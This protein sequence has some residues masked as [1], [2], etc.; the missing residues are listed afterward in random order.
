MAGL[1]SKRLFTRA[2]R[3]I[4]GGVN[5]PV[6]SFKAVGGTPVFAARGA[7]AYL[8]DADGRRYAD[9]C[10]S[11]GP[12]IFGH[13][14]K[15]IISAAQ[16]AMKKGTTFGAATE[17]EVLLA[18]SIKKAVPSIDSVRLTSSGTEAVFSALRLARAFTGRTLIVKFAGSYHGHVDSLLVGA[19]S[20]AATLGMPDSAGV[21]E[22]WAKT[23]IVLP[24]ND[25]Q[26]VVDAF[27]KWGGD[28][29]AVIVE[30]V[31][32]NMGVVLPEPGF[33]QTLRA[34]TS[35][36]QALL[37]FDE[38]I[39]GFRVGLGGAQGLYGIK[40][41]LT[42]LGKIIGGGFPLAAFG[43]RRDIME[44]LAPLGPVY[45]AG[46]L[47]GNPVAVAAGRKCLELLRRANPYPALEAAARG[48][49]RDAEAAAQKAGVPVMVN[50][51]ASM[52][53][54][55]FTES[56][57]RNFIEAKR[58]D[59]KRYGRFFNSLLE[60]GVYFPPAQFEAAFLSTEHDARVREQALKALG[61]ALNAL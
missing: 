60:A 8:F 42:C 35:K 38:V 32:G 45:Q 37:I 10:L 31:A 28:I 59:A 33:L 1:K 58:A 25:S 27:A 15:E 39:T 9:F 20:A 14:R 22:A 29:A 24:Y 3:A 40:P 43:G 4:S 36:H 54:I 49:V 61:R 7:G 16:A 18:E 47:S 51:A 56:P 48:F 55:F 57:V 13:A 19:G 53:T 21:P 34:Q 2:Q 23:T 6:R 50:R 52:F 26:A 11:W 46:T 44:L 17:G 5:S 30:P 12:L 41:D